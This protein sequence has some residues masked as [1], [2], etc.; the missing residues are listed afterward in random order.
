MKRRGRAQRIH[1]M[2]DVALVLVAVT[3][4]AFRVV[5]RQHAN[6]PAPAAP[7]TAPENW[8]DEIST[9]IRLDLPM[10]G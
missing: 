9:G 5:D 8:R 6:N 2:A 3:L 1:V 10:Q 7:K 4:L